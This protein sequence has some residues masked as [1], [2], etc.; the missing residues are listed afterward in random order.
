MFDTNVLHVILGRDHE[1]D[2]YRPILC[3]IEAALFGIGCLFWVDSM[4]DQ[5]GYSEATWGSFAYQFNAEFW[6][7]IMMAASAMTLIGLIRPIMR[8]MVTFGALI[9]T[10]QF[11]LLSYSA[12]FT[13]GEFVIAIYASVLFVPMHFWLMIEGMH[14]DPIGK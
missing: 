5:V 2:R 8:K 3:M 11:A 9:Q 1:L 7:F 6:A 12:A 13:G 10:V 14:R 4:T